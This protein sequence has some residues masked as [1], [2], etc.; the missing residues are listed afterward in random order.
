MKSP[1]PFFY[2]EKQCNISNWLFY[3]FILHWFEIFPKIYTYIGTVYRCICV[4]NVRNFPFWGLENQNQ[5]FGAESGSA[6]DSHLMGS[7][8]R[9]RFAN[10]DPDPEE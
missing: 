1:P 8:I 9:I 5:C 10:A 7:W 2:Y 4:Y 3:C 6:L